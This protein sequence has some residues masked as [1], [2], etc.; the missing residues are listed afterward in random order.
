MDGA[1]SSGEEGEQAVTRNIIAA[2]QHIGWRRNM[3][4]ILRNIVAIIPFFEFAKTFKKA[5][6]TCRHG[7]AMLDF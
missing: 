6:H 1:V 3:C 7:A 5:R 2:S 4:C